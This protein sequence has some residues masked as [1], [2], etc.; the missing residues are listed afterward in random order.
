MSENTSATNAASVVYRNYVLY[1][2][3]AKIYQAPSYQGLDG[4]TVT[5]AAITVQPVGYVVA[6]QL[7]SGL[8]GIF[9]PAGF[10]YALDADEKY[11]VG[12]IYTPPSTTET[13]TTAAT[14]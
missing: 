6:T 14:S 2:T 12:S 4:K 11:P 13:A 5:P 10:A 7:L 9:V 3:E 1:R 8:T